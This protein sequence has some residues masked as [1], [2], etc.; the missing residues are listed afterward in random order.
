[1][2]EKLYGSTEEEQLNYLKPRAIATIVFLIA[3]VIVLVLSRLKI[4]GGF[5]D[6]ISG[7]TG[8]G[9]IVIFFIWGW[10]VIKGL[11]GITTIGAIFSGKVVFGVVIFVFYVLLSYLAGLIFLFVGTLR[12]LYLQVKSGKASN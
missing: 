3:G 5:V 1:M 11:F 8:L 10:N 4:E 7:I 12:Y 6:I 9:L 2:L